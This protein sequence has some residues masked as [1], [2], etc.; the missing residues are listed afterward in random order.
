MH[1]IVLFYSAVCFGVYVILFELH[2]RRV[3]YKSG[4]AK[5]SPYF[6]GKTPSNGSDYILMLE[7]CQMQTFGVSE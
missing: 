2:I 4:K 1:T 5:G 3:G 6:C 7:Y